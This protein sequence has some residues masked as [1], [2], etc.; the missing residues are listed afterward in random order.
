MAPLKTGL[1]ALRNPHLALILADKHE[2]CGDW[3][4]R[5]DL[6][7]CYIGEMIRKAKRGHAATRRRIRE[8]GLQGGGRLHGPCLPIVRHPGKDFRKA[9]DDNVSKCAVLLA[10]IGPAWTT[11]KDPSGARRIDQ[12]RRLHAHRR[13]PPALTRG[14]DVIPVLV[15]GAQMPNAA[16][17]PDRPAGNLA[18][19]NGVELTH[20]RW[21]SDVE[22]LTRSLREYVSGGD[23]FQTRSIRSLSSPEEQSLWSPRLNHRPTHRSPA[24][25]QQSHSQGLMRMAAAFLVLVVAALL[26]AFAYVYIH[27]MFK[28]HKD[29]DVTPAVQALPPISNP[30]QALGPGLASIM[31]QP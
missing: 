16:E 13:L 7:Y 11:V 20:A 4:E 5:R 2:S 19:R 14:I 25:C 15:H 30:R 18:F 28:Q 3:D 23:M 10:M 12:M 29:Q 6:S 31:A 21:N 1:I 8:G 26:G 17:L 22:L 9:I 24:T 27:H